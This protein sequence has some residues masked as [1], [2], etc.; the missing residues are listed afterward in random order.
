MLVA[1][2]FQLDNAVA[3]FFS[4]HRSPALDELA[5]LCNQ[6]GDWPWVFLYGLAGTAAAWLAG[7]KWLLQILLAMLLS[8][9]VSGVL[10]NAVRFAAGRTRPGADVPQGFY[11]I[12]TEGGLFHHKNQYHSFPSAHT[13]CAVGFTAVVLFAEWRVGIFVLLAGIAVGCAR[14]YSGAHHFSDVV[15]GTMLGVATAWW[16]WRQ[17]QRHPQA[18]HAMLRWRTRNLSSRG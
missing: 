1:F 17:I 12:V 9:V 15:V 2:S 4:E 10:V 16:S 18:V 8:C 14:L 3:Q 5:H 13:A 6:F 11:G 7:K